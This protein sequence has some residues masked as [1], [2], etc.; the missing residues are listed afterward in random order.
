MYR[1]EVYVIVHIGI[2]IIYL[3]MAGVNHCSCP[4]HHPPYY[5]YNDDLSDYDDY[6]YTDDDDS[7][8]EFWESIASR[9]RNKYEIRKSMPKGMELCDYLFRIFENILKTTIIANLIMIT[10]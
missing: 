10:N 5:R 8:E 9:L 4:H 1:F 3:A 6:D 7:D 2:I